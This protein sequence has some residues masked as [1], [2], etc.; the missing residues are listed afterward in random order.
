M[1][2]PAD[3]KA[4]VAGDEG[5]AGSG[6]S[7]GKGAWDCDTN[8]GTSAFRNFAN[9]GSGEPMECLRC[10]TGGTHELCCV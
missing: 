2:K 10:L 3:D 9:S 5:G 1:T 4:L 6:V 8:T 7:L